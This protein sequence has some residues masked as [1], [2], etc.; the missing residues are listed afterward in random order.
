[1]GMTCRYIGSCPYCYA[2][3]LAMGLADGTDRGLLEVLT[4][5]P[6]GLQLLGGRRPLFDPVGWDPG[7]GIDAALDLL[8][9]S[10]EHSDSG[11]AA[12]ALNRLH[13]ATGSGPVLAGPVELGLLG[14]HPDAAGPS[15]LTT[16][17]WS[18]PSTGITSADAGSITSRANRDAR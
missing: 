1:M 4:G 18:S 16:S 17:C 12:A 11:D 15:V 10:W 6:F 14:H 2:N 8:G 7:I 9:W 3:C 5:A 13:E